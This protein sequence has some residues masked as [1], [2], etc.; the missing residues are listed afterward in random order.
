M[1]PHDVIRFHAN[2][3]HRLRGS[4]TIKQH[5]W[6]AAWLYLR[7]CP[8]PEIGTLHGILRH[9]EAETVTGDTPGPAKRA[10]HALDATLT[11][12]AWDYDERHGIPAADPE[13]LHLCDRLSDYLHMLQRAPDRADR[14][15]WPD[16]LAEITATARDLGVSKAVQAIMEAAQ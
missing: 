14:D 6:D 7:L 15:G 3:D 11:Q 12:L 9:D 4:I 1:I 16:S 10:S 2:R 13:W 8:S 5:Q